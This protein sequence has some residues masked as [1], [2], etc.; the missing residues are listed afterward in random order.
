MDTALKEI[1]DRYKTIAPLNEKHR[2]FL[3]HD[4]ALDCMCV[5]KILKTYN[6][7]V[8]KRVQAAKIKGL[9]EIYRLTEKDGELTVIEEYIDGETIA[10]LL[11]R[12]GVFPEDKVRDIALKLCDILNDLHSMEPPVIHRDIKPSNVIVT[13]TGE[14]RLIDLN[15]AKL[16]NAEKAEDTVLLGTYGYAAPEQFG[17]GSSTVQ[18]D[19]YAVGML[20]NT[21]LLGEYSRDTIKGNSLSETIARCVM[22][23]TEDR[24]GSALELR[25]ALV[26]P[27]SKP[28]VSFVLPGFRSKN[29]LHMIIAVLGYAAI[30]IMGLT[31]ETTNQESNPKVIWLERIWFLIIMLLL[32]FFTSDYLGIQ[33]KLPLCNSRNLIIRIIG[34]ILFDAVIAIGL[35]FIMV[36]LEVMMTV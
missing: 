34:I 25:A 4:E 27:G 3:A 31:F 29:P 36:G 26:S 20:M 24:Y 16:E 7:D 12:E 32:V 17:F 23:R 19:I 6:A 33:K 11:E 21:M 18:T 1:E 8:Y 9:P 2:V 10:S 13:S 35:L 15:A 28:K 5:K 22:I 14:V 30:I